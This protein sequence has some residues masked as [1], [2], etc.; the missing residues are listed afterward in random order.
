MDILATVDVCVNDV[1]PT[2]FCDEEGFD[3]A[4]LFTIRVIPETPIVE[5][6]SGI[7]QQEQS[8]P[9][10]GFPSKPSICA[11]HEKDTQL[12]TTRPCILVEIGLAF[13]D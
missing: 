5:T 8:K 7:V 9:K 1:T 2:A 10:V 6:K 13:R 11:I 3:L 12:T 4:P